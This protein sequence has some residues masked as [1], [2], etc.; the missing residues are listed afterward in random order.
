MTVTASRAGAGTGKRTLPW[1][2]LHKAARAYLAAGPLDRIAIVRAGVP[3]NYVET[4]VRNAAITKELLYQLLA[5]RRATIDRK[6]RL[7]ERLSSDESQ[8][9]LAFTELVGE[10]DRIV[11]ESGNPEGFDAATWVPRWL[12][13]PHP[14]LGGQRPGDLMDTEDGRALVYRL[15]IQ[16]QTGAYA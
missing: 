8:R 11:R 1:N 7:H 13:A 9:L 6:I 14:A 12:N 4:L 3:A 16:Q 15:L 2:S 5:L 10:A